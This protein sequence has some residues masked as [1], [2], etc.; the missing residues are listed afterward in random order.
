MRVEIRSAEKPV[1]PDASMA[2]F[3]GPIR[4]AVDARRSAGRAR[5]IYEV[6]RFFGLPERRVKAAVYGE[7]KRVLADELAQVQTRLIAHLEAEERRLEAQR[8]LVA[9]RRAA[10]IEDRASC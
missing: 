6:A 4:E 7:V 5:A 3:C 2:A 10:L 1:S 9:A 8:A